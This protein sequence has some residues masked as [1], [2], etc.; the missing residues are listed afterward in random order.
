MPKAET[1][2]QTFR[3]QDGSFEAAYDYVDQLI[4]NS[5][6]PQETASEAMLVF[7]ALMQKLI[8]WGIGEDT[9]IQIS[10]RNKL[11]DLGIRIGFEGPF[12]TLGSDGQDSI[13]DRILEGYDDRLDVS[14]HSGYNVISISVRRNYRTSLFACLIATLLSVA[15]YFPLQAF[16]DDTA[17]MTLLTEFIFPLEKVFTNAALM[18]GAP[19]T[20][21]SLLKNL[22][23]TYV[24]A[25]RSS[26]LRKLQAKTLTTSLLAIALAFVTVLLTSSLVSVAQGGAGQTIKL[27]ERSFSE[28][29]T[30]LVEPSIFAPFEAVSP[31]PLMV[32]ALLVTYGMC[33]VGKHFD[34]IRQAMMACYSLF[35]RMLRLIMAA[36]PVFCFLAILEILLDTGLRSI[37][38]IAAYCILLNVALLMLYA[39]YALRLRAHGIKVI[40]FVR[41]LVP[42][43]REN[44]KIGSVI[45]ATP[46][47][48]RYCSRVFKM[49]R[50]LLERNLPVLAQINLDG[51]CFIITFF[52]LGLL[53][54]ADPTVSMLMLVGISLLVLLLSY[55]AP[56]QPGSI[57]IGI[58]IVSMSL[59][60]SYLLCVAIYAEAFLG[61]A[62]NTVNAVGDIVAAAIEDKLAQSDAHVEDIKLVV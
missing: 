12:F 4:S 17:K 54:R 43:V 55:G 58:L 24:V 7:E 56:N 22:T 27:A 46:Y 16:L 9:D 13:E 2:Q 11:G 14:Y 39:T 40:P 29:I 44:I 32:L 47:N 34:L 62:Q 36:L 5:N 19:M 57:L 33:S 15:A 25:Q 53:V 50:P 38:G 59:D 61:G 18:V 31:V 35:S 8:D 23:D 49:K 51:N 20:F 45:D 41:D 60:F 28:V 21:F 48:I 3:I 26:G 52:S 30:T 1:K 10:G 42:L 37:V 6:I